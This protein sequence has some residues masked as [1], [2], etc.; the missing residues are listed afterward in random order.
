MPRKTASVPLHADEIDRTKEKM[1]SWAEA[2]FGILVFADSNNYPDAHG[3]YECLLG[4]GATHRILSDDADA[5]DRLQV[6]HDEHADWVFFHLTYDLKNVL[7]ARLQSRHPEHYGWPCLGATVPEVVC[8]ILRGGQMLHIETQAGDPE[9]LAA[10]IMGTSIAHS[11]VLPELEFTS[12]FSKDEYLLRIA[13]LKEHIRNG[14]CYEVNFCNEGFAKIAGLRARAVFSRLNSASPAPFAAFYKDG[15]RYMMCASPERFLAGAGRMV[16]SQPI[17]GT[18][19]RG[20]DAEEDA[21]LIVALRNSE[22]ERAENVMI[23]DLV[24]SDLARTCLPGSVHVDELFG[25][26]SYP[27]VHQMISTISGEMPADLPF[28]QAIAQAFPMGSMTGAPKHKVM[29]FIDRYEAARRELFS[30]S[31][32]YISPDGNFD[33]NVV[34]RAL[35][36]NAASGYL[37]YQSGGAITWDSDAEEE[38][39]EL[40]L[41]ARAMEQLF[42][43]NI[44]GR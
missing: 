28:T 18:A 36:Y 30:G 7:H 38:W 21:A 17:K 14:D 20:V 4:A 13:T 10:E 25:I 35:F 42:A 37:S 34:I 16:C 32:G 9:K 1:L 39:A 26:Y 33:M 43:A 31:V 5:F 3:R 12:R 8:Y 44:T 29:Q 23:T 11:D 40:R 27:Q 22:K 2:R 19:R 24:R 41:K 15:E 6:L